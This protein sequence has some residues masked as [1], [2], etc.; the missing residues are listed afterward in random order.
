MPSGGAGPLIAK[1]DE[2]LARLFVGGLLGASR[3]LRGLLPTISYLF[4]HSRLP[5][6]EPAPTGLRRA[7]SPTASVNPDR[8]FRFSRARQFPCSL[9]SAG[10]SCRLYN[11][12]L[13]FPRNG[14][15]GARPMIAWPKPNELSRVLFLR[16]DEVSAYER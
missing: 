13:S 7:K 14:R 12:R 10:W 4:P 1:A 15:T 11:A 16:K 2:K 6:V 5:T 8:R 9:S 3:I